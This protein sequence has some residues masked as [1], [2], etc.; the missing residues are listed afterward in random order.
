MFMPPLNEAAWLIIKRKSN[1]GGIPIPPFF[2]EI[3]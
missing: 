3:H 1:Q 2:R